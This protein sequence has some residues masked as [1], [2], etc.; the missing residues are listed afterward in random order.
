MKRTRLRATGLAVMLLSVALPVAAHAQ[1]MTTQQYRHP[2]TEKDLNF[3]KAYLTGIKDGL[4]A[5]NISSETKLFCM[6]GNPPLSFEKADDVILHWL[7]KKGVDAGS[8]PIGLALLYGLKEAYP[9]PQ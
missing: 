5:Y 2:K 3:N 9:C 7:S 6:P 1:G 4:F 8:L